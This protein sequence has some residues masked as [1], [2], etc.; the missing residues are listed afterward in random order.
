LRHESHPQSPPLELRATTF[1]EQGPMLARK[2]SRI[3]LTRKSP[4]LRAVGLRTGFSRTIFPRRDSFF[5]AAAPPDADASPIEKFCELFFFSSLASLG[6]PFC[7]GM[8][9]VSE[10]FFPSSDIGLS[11]QRWCSF[12]QPPLTFMLSPTSTQAAGPIRQEPFLLFAGVFGL[13]GLPFWSVT[14]H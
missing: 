8:R 9:I 14:P 7:R 6:L 12:Y 2:S 10:R 11:L 3:C 13:F 5:L 1:S 4:A